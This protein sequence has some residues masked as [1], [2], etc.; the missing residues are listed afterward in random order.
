MLLF[1]QSFQL[2]NKIVLTVFYMLQLLLW[3]CSR[4]TTTF[5]SGKLSDTTEKSST[6]DERWINRLM[7]S[8]GLTKYNK[9]VSLNTTTIYNNNILKWCLD[10][11]IDDWF[12]FNTIFNSFSF[13]TKWPVHLTMCFPAF[14]HKYFTHHSKE[15]GYLELTCTIFKLIGWNQINLATMNCQSSEKIKG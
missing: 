9:A 5:L 12:E 4:Q 7:K 11:V 15:T 10:I 1:S 3:M 13:T 2:C 8:T 6:H 14:L